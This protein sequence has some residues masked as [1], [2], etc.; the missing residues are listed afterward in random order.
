MKLKILSICSA[1]TLLSGGDIFARNEVDESSIDV[2]SAREF[3]KEKDRSDS[4]SKL[5]SKWQKEFNFENTDSKDISVADEEENFQPSREPDLRAETHVSHDFTEFC[6]TIVSDFDNLKEESVLLKKES[7]SLNSIKSPDKQV[8][9]VSA[10]KEELENHKNKLDKMILDLNKLQTWFEKFNVDKKISE[11]N[12]CKSTVDTIR[13]EAARIQLSLWENKIKSYRKA[14]SQFWNVLQN[15]AVTKDKIESS[16]R[17]CFGE[18]GGSFKLFDLKLFSAE[19]FDVSN[20]GNNARDSIKKDWTEICETL[21]RDTQETWSELMK[22][23]PNDP[24]YNSTLKG[25]R[26]KAKA[27]HDK[28]QSLMGKYTDKGNKM[29][30]RGI[31]PHELEK[32]ITKNTEK[33]NKGKRKHQKSK[34]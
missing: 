16:G 18:V 13:Q 27:F 30:V 26:E 7:E 4:R 20:I 8:K 22:L 3:W 6:E 12:S 9:Q 17:K 1:I 19:I 32:K 21:Y 10:L 29:D 25:L 2:K 33:I 31:T 5:P 23:H 34:N 11:L 15:Y 24:E 28:I 14:L